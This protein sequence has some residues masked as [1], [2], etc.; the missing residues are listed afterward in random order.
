[1][2]EKEPQQEQSSGPTWS[3][4]SLAWELGYTIA[5]PIALLGFSGA[6]ADRYFDTSPLFL[7]IGVFLSLAISTIGIVRKTKRILDS[8]TP[9][10]K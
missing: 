4:V 7:L 1:M 10:K 2:I 8:F 6:Y 5:I 3:A 9:P